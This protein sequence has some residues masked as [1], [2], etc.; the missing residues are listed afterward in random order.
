MPEICAWLKF[1]DIADHW[2]D[3]EQLDDSLFRISEPHV[4]EFMRANM[5]VVR[6]TKDCLLVDG[7]NGVVPLKPFLAAHGLNPTI[8]VASHAH[9][10]HVGALHEWPLT[11]VHKAEADGLARIDPNAT[12]AGKNYNI[13]DM[14]TLMTGDASLTGPMITALPHAGYKAGDY[15]LIAPQVEAIAD[16]HRIDLG[17]RSFEV[18]HVPGHCP[19]QLAFWD[20]DNSVLLGCDAIY[21]DEPLDTLRHSNRTDYARSLRRLLALEPHVTHGG[22]G[23]PMN[24]PRFRQ[25]IEGYLKGIQ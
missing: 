2:F 24:T 23:G 13:F 20:A 15:R 12:L 4:V 3:I 5:F 25:I 17:N 14:T 10:D 6:G 19:G 7:G 8:V 11:L 9:A 18:L 22:H 16:G 1:M 21:D